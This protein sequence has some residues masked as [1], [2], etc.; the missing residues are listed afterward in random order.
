V[1]DLTRDDLIIPP[2]FT[3]AGPRPIDPDP[4]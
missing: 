3:T 4:S 2:D 1:H